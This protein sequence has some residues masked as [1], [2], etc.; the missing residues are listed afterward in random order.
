MQHD[1]A[2]VNHGA[3]LYEVAIFMGIFDDVTHVFCCIAA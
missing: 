3:S 1:F 2:R